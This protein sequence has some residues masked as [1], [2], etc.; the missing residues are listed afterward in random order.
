MWTKIA[1]VKNIHIN[2]VLPVIMAGC[3]QLYKF[4]FFR[5]FVKIVLHIFNVLIVK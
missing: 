2:N 4:Y 1:R 5:V 3:N